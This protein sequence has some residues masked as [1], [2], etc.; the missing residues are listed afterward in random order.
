MGEQIFC[1]A[2]AKKRRNTG[3]ISRFFDNGRR[4]IC[5]PDA[6]GDL[7]RGSLDSTLNHVYHRT[8]HIIQIIFPWPRL[9]PRTFQICS[10]QFI[11][12]PADIA[13]VLT[14]PLS[15]LFFLHYLT[16]FPLSSN[17]FKQALRAAENLV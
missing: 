15:P 8:K 14:H 1:L 7:F 3:C 13:W 16:S 10:N 4:K 6:C 9:F 11:F 17:D 2:K 12:F 5:R